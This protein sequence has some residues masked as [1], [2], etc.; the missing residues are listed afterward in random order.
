[1]QKTYIMK[2]IYNQKFLVL[3]VI[4]L[5]PVFSFTQTITT[6][7]ENITSCPG[8]IIVPLT[9]DSFYNVAAMSLNLEYNNQE[10]NYTGYQNLNDS[11]SS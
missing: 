3:L 7:V 5:I 4:G 10:L 6:T 9:V 1:M 11:L 8:N 2:S